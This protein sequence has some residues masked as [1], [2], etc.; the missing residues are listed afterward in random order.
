[1][2][3]ELD[4]RVGSEGVEVGH[5]RR[6]A[7]PTLASRPVQRVTL[8]GETVHELRGHDLRQLPV[9]LTEASLVQKRSS[10]VLHPTDDV[11]QCRGLVLGIGGGQAVVDLV[12]EHVG[13]GLVREQVAVSIRHDHL[14]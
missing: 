5:V 13:H 4:V 10:D 6:H 1:M 11:V 9:L 14:D 8:R 2:R 3:L 12:L 7:V